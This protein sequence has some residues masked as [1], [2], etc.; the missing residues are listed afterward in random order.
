VVA[1][2]A[3]GPATA[4]MVVGVVILVN[5]LEGDLLSP[6]VLGKVLSLHPLAVL[7]ALTAGT[8]A[9]GITGAILAVPFAV[10]RDH[11]VARDRARGANALQPP[12]AD[13][14]ARPRLTGRP[15]AYA[16]EPASRHTTAPTASREAKAHGVEWCEDEWRWAR[17]GNTGTEERSC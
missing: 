17:L 8:I 2:L 5:Q 4:L 12:G 9:A 11:D 6:L 15:R 14:R 7:L 13:A 10:G 16:A 3:N 1:L